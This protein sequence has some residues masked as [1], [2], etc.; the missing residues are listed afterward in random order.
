MLPD[1]FPSNPSKPTCF[2][3]TAIRM[4][5]GEEHARVHCVGF[6]SCYAAKHWL[7][8]IMGDE[9]AVR[10]GYELRLDSGIK[11]RSYQIDAILAHEFTA[12][13]AAYRLPIDYLRWIPVFRRGVWDPKPEPVV[14]ETITVPQSKAKQERIAKKP[15]VPSGYVPVSELVKGTAVTPMS[16]RALLRASNYVKPAYGWAFGPKDLKKVKQLL[17]V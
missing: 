7:K 13:E 17:G 3:I 10:V 15:P 4:M 6:Y 5:E 8:L 12:E 16:A 11:L 9:G 14:T 1:P 2:A